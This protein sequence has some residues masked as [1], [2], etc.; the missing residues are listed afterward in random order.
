MAIC[1]N[2]QKKISA[3]IEGELTGPEE[4]KFNSHLE[5]CSSCRAR[6]S[7]M[8]MLTSNLGQLPKYKTSST[9]DV[10]LRSRIR[11][12]MNKGSFV[13]IFNDM[14]TP[15]RMSMY[16]TAAVIFISLGILIDQQ[17]IHNQPALLSTQSNTVNSIP[18]QKVQPQTNTVQKSFVDNRYRAKIEK[19]P[20]VDTRKSIARDNSNALS[21]ARIFN[22][23]SLRR[24][25]TVNEPLFTQTSAVIRF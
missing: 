9:F 11:A 13:N 10:E 3:Y 21:R 22:D 12:E 16:A 20:A 23:D 15:L 2:F 1:Y 8:K 5:K 4:D 24:Q 25:T 19:R 14:R 7:N 17:Y 6:V 18:L